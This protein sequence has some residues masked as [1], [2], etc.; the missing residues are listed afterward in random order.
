MTEWN[1]GQNGAILLFIEIYI[2]LL[3]FWKYVEI[4]HFLGTRVPLK[5]FYQKF[6]GKF[7]RYFF[8]KLEFME[9]E[10]YG[11]LEFLKNRPLSVN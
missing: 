8:K 9:L 7:E 3:L 11:K 4:Y 6:F 5:I 2:N 1:N 10:L